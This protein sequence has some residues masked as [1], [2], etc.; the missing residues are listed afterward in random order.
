M[1]GRAASLPESGANQLAR[2]VSL[3][4][5]PIHGTNW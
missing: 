1:V 4:Q 5:R 2:V 3:F